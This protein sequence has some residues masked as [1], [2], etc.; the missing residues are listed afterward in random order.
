MKR[1]MFLLA[2][3]MAISLG[4]VSAPSSWANSLTF[5]DVTFNLYDSGSNTLT[6]EIN[7]VNNA[8]G[9]WD[10]IDKLESFALKDLGV[11]TLTASAA[12]TGDGWLQNTLE[13]NTAGCAGGSSGGFC[14]YN[15]GGYTLANNNTFVMNYTGTLDLT[16]PHLKV[17]FSG[18][19]QGDGHGSLLSQTVPV[20]GT[21]LMF[22]LGM[23]ALFGW[24][25]RSRSQVS[26]VNLAV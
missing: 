26:P 1:K 23:V 15:P 7:G 8:S 9:D 5:Q 18:A 6:L 24:H 2:G 20:P 22:G 25:Y 12:M 14:F 16:A 11:T 17:L 21:A 13:L 19:N 4:L 3:M 10:G